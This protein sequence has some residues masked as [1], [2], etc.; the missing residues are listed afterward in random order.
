M[1]IRKNPIDNAPAVKTKEVV[2]AGNV[3]DSTDYREGFCP[4]CQR[5]M[6][7]TLVGTIPSFVCEEHRTVLPVRSEQ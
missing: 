4:H 1:T 6:V 3:E 5:P 2:T 7:R